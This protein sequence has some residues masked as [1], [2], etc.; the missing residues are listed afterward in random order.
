MFSRIAPFFVLLTALFAPL[1]LRAEV[2]QSMQQMQLSFAPL[3]K[4]TSPAVVNIYAQR[5]VQAQMTPF[6]ADPFFAQ[7]F[8]MRGMGGLLQERIEKSLGSGVIVDPDGQIATNTHVIRGATEIT[9]VTSDGREFA[10]EKVLDDPKSDLAILRIKPKGAKLHY[11]ELA[12]SDQAEVGDLV[13]AIGN[14]FGV[15]Q[16]VTSGIISGLSRSNVQGAGEYS[17][18]IQT[19]AAINPGNSG[20]ALIDMRGRLLGINSMIYSKDG[21]SLGIG[22]AI[23]S[24]MLRTVIDASRH[25]GKVVR[26]WTGLSGQAVTPDMVESLGLERATGA[27]INRVNPKSPAYKAGIRSG[28]VILSV[29]DHDVADPDALKFRI[30][31]VPIGTPVKVTLFRGGKTGSA[32]LVA[33][34]PPEDPPRDETTLKGRH[35]LSGAVVV[36]ISPAV[37]EELGGVA[38]ESGVVVVKANDGYAARFGLQEGD[39]ILAVNGDKIG[40]VS[41]LRDVLDEDARRWALQIMRGSRV[42]NLILTL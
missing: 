32:T 39:I 3:V 1:A 42:M 17:F 21:G 10:A 2:P 13:L 35:P 37:A 25:G 24:S 38:Q 34:A 8:A 27:L 7:F 41:D 19:D 18:F 4:K 9:V 12:D 40:S 20:G 5:K 22:F 31:T 30:A 6:M 11:L 16:T 23:P 29:N 36:N 28:D 33:E 26:A 14:P 15:G